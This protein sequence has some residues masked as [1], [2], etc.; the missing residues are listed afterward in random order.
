LI[1]RVTPHLYKLSPRNNPGKNFAIIVSDSGKGLIL[2]CGLFP[3]ETLDQ[4]ILGMRQHLGLKSIDAFWISHMH[5]EHFLLGPT[6][7][8]KYGAEAWTLDIIA[9]KCENPRRYD[10]ASMV[11][12]Y[13]DGFDG[14]K[15]DKRFRDG[16]SIEWE[17]YRIQ[18]DWMPGQTE[19]GCCL[20][21]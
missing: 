19:V 12:A 3:E 14:M 11:S 13:G 8:R 4:I 21:L 7:K 17:G 6:L 9:D 2:D 16:E 20:C 5:G 10:Y 15:I 1:N 18:V